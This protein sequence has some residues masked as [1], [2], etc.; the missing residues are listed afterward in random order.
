MKALQK[1][2][3]AAVD[4]MSSQRWRILKH[5]STQLSPHDIIVFCSFSESM[6]LQL[7]PCVWELGVNL[8]WFL[9]ELK[10][11]DEGKGEWEGY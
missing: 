2:F 1:Y 11:F 4:Y 9:L 7:V 8:H 5:H 3:L 6:R 10:T